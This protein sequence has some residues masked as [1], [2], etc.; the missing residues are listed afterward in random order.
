MRE[1]FLPWNSKHNGWLN[2][3]FLIRAKK[4]FIKKL[5][6]MKKIVKNNVRVKAVQLNQCLF[7]T[8]DKSNKFLWKY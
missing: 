2:V 5:L 1:N 6:K 8:N 7:N 3:I 4:N